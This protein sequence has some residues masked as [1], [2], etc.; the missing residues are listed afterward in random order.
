MGRR[1]PGAAGNASGAAVVSLFRRSRGAGAGIEVADG[2]VRWARSRHQGD[3]DRH[4][5]IIRVDG[6]NRAPP[7][8][9]RWRD[10]RES[11]FFPASGTEVEHHPA[12]RGG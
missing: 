5:T 3:Q 12:Q 4:G 11:V 9:V 1:G 2:D 8:L 6:K 10:G 7:Y